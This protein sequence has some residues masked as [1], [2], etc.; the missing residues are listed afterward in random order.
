VDYL[1]V[2]TVFATSSHA[3]RAAGGVALVGRAAAAA[4]STPVLA[5]GGITPERVAEVLEAGA[6]GVAVV[7]GV[8]GAADP[9]MAVRG[10]LES[11]D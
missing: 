8:W 9:G 7:S 5:I 1:V 10:Y 2:G 6:R 3:G 4:G 11:L